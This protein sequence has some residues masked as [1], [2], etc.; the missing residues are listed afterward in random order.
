MR[1]QSTPFQTHCYLE[2]LVAPEIEPGTSVCAARNSGTQD[3]GG[4]QL[5]NTMRTYF[6]GEGPGGGGVGETNCPE[7]LTNDIRITVTVCLQSNFDPGEE[8]KCCSG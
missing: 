7:K 4:G 2:Y 1:A 8:S 6:T 5:W 3:H